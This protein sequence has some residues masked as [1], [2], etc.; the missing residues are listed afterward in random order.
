MTFPRDDTTVTHLI[1][2]A[3]AHQGVSSQVGANVG[4]HVGVNL[5]AAITPRVVTTSVFPVGFVKPSQP[6]TRSRSQRKVFFRTTYSLG[7]QLI[8][9]NTKYLRQT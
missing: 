2:S 9:V 3:D 1:K 4:P 8:W 5:D 7:K 6:V